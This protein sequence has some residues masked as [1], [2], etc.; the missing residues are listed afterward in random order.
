MNSPRIR[1][2]LTKGAYPLVNIPKQHPKAKE[3]HHIFNVGKSP[4]NGALS[5]AKCSFEGNE[6]DVSGMIFDETGLWSAK[7]K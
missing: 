2:L 5:I 3:N 7:F 6:H 4:R 1:D